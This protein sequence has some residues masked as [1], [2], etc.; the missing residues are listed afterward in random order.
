MTPKASAARI[1]AMAGIGH[2]R[3]VARVATRPGEGPRVLVVEDHPVN[4][5]VLVLQLKLLGIAADSAENGVDALAAWAR[6]RYAAVLADIHMP[7]MDGHELA[8]F[9]II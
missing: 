9:A 3:R 5:E 1:H 6:G 8:L 2:A 4:R 7:H